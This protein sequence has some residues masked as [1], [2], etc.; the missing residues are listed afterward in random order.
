M[1]RRTNRPHRVEWELAY[2]L[3]RERVVQTY[4]F[5]TSLWFPSHRTWAGESITWSSGSGHLLCFR[6]EGCG[7]ESCLS[8][9]YLDDTGP[10]LAFDVPIGT[11]ILFPGLF[12]G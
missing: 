8:C 5:P 2:L 1:A 6:T 12:L 3:G 9:C 4:D 10:F 7:L 11:V